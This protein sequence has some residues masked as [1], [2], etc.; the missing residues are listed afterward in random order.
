ML[1]NMKLNIIFHI[2]LK[3]HCISFLTI[4]PI[5][6]SEASSKLCHMIDDCHV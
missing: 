3:A 5:P 6:I 2:E 4:C 1:R